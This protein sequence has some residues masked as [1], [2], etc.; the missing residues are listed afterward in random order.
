M[1]KLS[2]QTA[3]ILD[4]YGIDAGFGIIADAGFDCVDFNIDHTLPGGNIRGG[5]LEGF[6]DQTDAQMIEALKPYADAAKK[7]GVGFGQAHAPFPSYVHEAPKTNAYVLNAIKKVMMLLGEVGCPWLVVH[8]AFNAYSD[9]LSAE[10]EWKINEEMYSELI[11]V[12]KETG[13]KVATENMFSSYKRKIIEAVMSDFNFAASFVDHMNEI[14][15]EKLFGFCL[16]VGH[17]TLLHRDQRKVINTMGERITVLHLHDNDGVSDQ[18]LFPYEGITDWDAVCAG[19]KDI[20]YKGTLS[21]ETFNAIATR[22][23]G[24]AP[25]L[26]KL[27][28]SIG[29]Q[30]AAKIEG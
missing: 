18:H 24:L 10:E 23:D 15:G 9:R 29:R 11:P 22:A 27:L 3:P 25:E 19:L 26:L 1:L 30:F 6:F 28:A 4:T 17:A 13:V 21:F 2:V 14:A 20:G 7:H 16:D 12:I 8:P 5:K